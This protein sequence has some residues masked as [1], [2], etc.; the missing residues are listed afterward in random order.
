MKVQNNYTDEFRRNVV[1]V[2]RSGMK[3]YEVSKRLRIPTT[4]IFD[5]LHKDKY[6]SVGPAS[7]EVLA[8]LP[9]K[10]FAITSS[11]EENNSLVKIE[12]KRTKPVEVSKSP[13]KISYGKLNMEFPN[14]LKTKDLKAIIQALGGRDV[15]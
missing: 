5:W 12:K 14:G 9:P 15:L 7:E 6:S 3:A 2:V 8:A 10:Q 11:R 13:I 1:A 4:T